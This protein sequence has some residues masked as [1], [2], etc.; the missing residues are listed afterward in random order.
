VSSV[1]RDFL[2]YLRSGLASKEPYVPKLCRL[3]D[4]KG[5]FA[6]VDS[7]VFAWCHSPAMT[8]LLPGL[9]A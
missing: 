6:S 5:A 4:T 3:K 7:L 9:G 1:V 2:E 8:G